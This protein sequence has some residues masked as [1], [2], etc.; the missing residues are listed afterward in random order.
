MIEMTAQT[1]V[2]EVD[3]RLECW[4]CGQPIEADSSVHLGNHPEVGVCLR[5]AH[6][7]HKQAV[8][9]EDALRPTPAARVRDV[10]RG[11]R[12]VVMD[13][14]WQHTPVVGRALR[15]LGRYTP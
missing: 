5:C 8:A 1:A 11:A 12:S 13:H 6:F 7:L 4:C 9:R 10:F 2:G 14:G 3:G 15:W